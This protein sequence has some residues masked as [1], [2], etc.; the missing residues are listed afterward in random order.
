MRQHEIGHTELTY[1][2]EPVF[3][4]DADTPCSARE[5]GALEQL[6]TKYGGKDKMH[7]SPRLSELVEMIAQKNGRSLLTPAGVLTVERA[8]ELSEALKVRASSCVRR[9]VCVELRV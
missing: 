5:C 6:E 9:A 3:Y 7:L 8:K 2:E 1:T 4:V